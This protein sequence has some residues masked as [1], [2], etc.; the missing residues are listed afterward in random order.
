[1]IAASVPSPE[2]VERAVR[3]ELALPKYRLGDPWWSRL[4]EWLEQAWIRLLEVA[5][6]LA[7]RVGGPLVLAILIGG[8]VI[9]VT[10]AVTANLGRRRTRLVEERV[11]REREVARGLDPADL[12]R[13][14]REAEATG[15]HA[16]AMRWL[17]QALLLRLDRAGR[18]EFRPA[19]TSATI[20]EQLGSPE[21]ARAVTRF[22]EVVYGGREATPDDPRLLRALGAGLL[23]GAKR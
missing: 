3:E 19:S 12:E 18:I 14:A 13:Q 9:A 10:I 22:D 23:A 4:A 7:E 15:D 5:A 11:R 1:M 16:M 21:F 20:T 17:F 8:A 6:A 2:Q